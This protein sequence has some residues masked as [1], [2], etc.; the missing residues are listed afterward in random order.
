MGTS[1]G[2]L[3]LLNEVVQRLASVRPDLL[4]ET[5]GGYPPMT[6]PPTTGKIHPKQRLGWAHW[7]RYMAYGYDDPRYERKKNLEAWRKAAP[8]GVTVIQ[9]Y[10]DNFAEPWVMSPFAIAIQG[11]R[12][13]LLEHSIDSIYFLIYPPGYWWNHSLNTYLSARCF[14]D[15]SL[16]PFDLIEDYAR[17]YYGP[18]AGPLLA[19]YYD[20]W[21]R[22]PDLCYRV[23]GSTTRQDRE[24]LARQRKTLIE[25]AIQAADDDPVC[26]YRVAKVA[27]LHTFAERLAEGHHLR[28][29]VQLARRNGDF[30]KAAKLL[31]A[32]RTY[33]DAIMGYCY[34][35]ALR[36]QGLLD[37]NEVPGL[38]KR[39]VKSWL[40]VEAKAIAAKD[41]RVNEAELRKELDEADAPIPAF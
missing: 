24:T 28:R 33:T 10:S 9:Y 36:D 37:K 13:Y 34:D 22:D 17:H 15:A 32:A 12:K 5:V 7:G 6:E 26:A 14:H 40:D 16:D 4:V 3:S 39:G 38:I 23:R 30:A 19:E 29:Q 11:D 41:R 8:G 21:A 35:L 31:E 2:L 1:N 25:P 27:A 18:K 20:Q